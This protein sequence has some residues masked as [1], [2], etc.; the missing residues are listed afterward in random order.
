MSEFAILC[1]LHGYKCEAIRVF[2]PEHVLL[3]DEEVVIFLE[4]DLKREHCWV[5]TA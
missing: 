4:H 3:T 2:F 1:G 5:F